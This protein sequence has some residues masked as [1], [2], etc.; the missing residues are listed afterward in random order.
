MSKSIRYAIALGLGIILVMGL[1]VFAFGA[2]TV[3]N[4]EAVYNQYCAGCHGADGRGMENIRGESAREVMSVTRSGEDDMPAY[5][6]NIIS[7]ADLQALGAYVA[8]GLQSTSG[9]GDAG[10]DQ[11]GGGSSG[12]DEYDGGAGG[13]Q[14]GGGDDHDDDDHD[15]D[16]YGGSDDDDDH[17]DHY[18]DRDDRDR[19]R[20]SSRDRD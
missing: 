11:Y 4:G 19:R 18:G 8:G 16:H 14:Y 5:G 6:R 20:S 3:S 9:S 17:D 13:D 10:G 7:D 15:D 12:D 1:S 2:D